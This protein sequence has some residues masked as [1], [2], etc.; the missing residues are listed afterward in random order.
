ML[1]VI[2]ADDERIQ[3]EGIAKHVDWQAYGMQ[4]VGLAKDGVQALELI[5]KNGID[6]L[7]TDIKMPKMHGLELAERAQ[8]LN[9]QVK[10]LIISGYNDFEYARA[11]IE[12]KAY[13]FLLK[14]ILFDKLFQELDKIHALIVQEQHKQQTL[15]S[16]KEQIQESKPLLAEKLFQH[17]LHGFLRDEE[18]IRNRMDTLS[19]P[20]PSNGYDTL[21]LQI[22]APLDSPETDAKKQLT[23]LQFLDQIARFAA[24]EQQ[25][26]AFQTKENEFAI[27]LYASELDG[28]SPVPDVIR[29]VRENL[30]LP[31]NEMLTISISNRKARLSQLHEAYKECEAA[32]RQKFYLGKGKDIYYL[33]SMTEQTFS[34]NY[35]VFYEQLIQAV[36][37]G[38]VNQVE[39][40]IE[41]I[42]K[43]FTQMSSGYKPFIKAFC[44]R[45]MSDLIRIIHESN[46]KIESVFGEEHRLWD[47]IYSFDTLPEIHEWLKETAVSACRHLHAKRTRKNTNIIETIIQNLETRYHEPITIDELAKRIHLTPN[48]I[49]NIFKEY[50]G[51][52]IIDYLTKVRMKHAIRLLTDES[53]RIYEVAEQTG[54]NSTSYFS[55]VFKNMYG[56]SPKEYRDQ[57]LKS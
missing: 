34:A 40:T 49:S 14:P 2:I 32:S 10:I 36:E 57:S 21:L 18:F 29:E 27:V 41:E 30:L 5:E 46:E 7:I 8:Q 15:V 16:L 45:T 6:L 38:N 43:E 39:Q 52:S 48:Y 56:I 12:L 47:R 51:E 50:V 19:L 4:I 9:P 31:Y 13:A 20:L 37:I 17:I 3:R 11:A 22:D 54:Y 26:Q 28:P 53:V 23:Y 44:F 1:K 55:V 42:C 35:D 24:I 25:G 33:D